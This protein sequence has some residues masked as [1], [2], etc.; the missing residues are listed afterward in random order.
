[1]V[2]GCLPFEVL[3]FQGDGQICRGSA[4]AHGIGDGGEGFGVDAAALQFLAF[5]PDDQFIGKKGDG[6]AVPFQ[7][8]ILHAQVQGSV[9]I[10]DDHAAGAVDGIPVFRPFI[11]GMGREAVVLERGEGTGLCILV[12]EAA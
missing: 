5:L 8:A 6:R 1:M 12:E 2:G 9:G 7:P 3:V 10:G 4:P 11:C